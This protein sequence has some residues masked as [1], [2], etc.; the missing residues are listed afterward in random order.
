MKHLVFL[1]ACIVALVFMAPATSG[2]LDSWNNGTNSTINVGVVNI[3]PTNVVGAIAGKQASGNYVTALTGDV[4]ASGP[5]SVAA[6]L[7][8][9]GT[10]GTYRSVTTD[11]K[12][13]VTAGT[14]PTTFSGY[15]ISDTSANLAA[16]L[17]DETG[18]SGVAVFNSNPSITNGITLLAPSSHSLSYNGLAA[19]SLLFQNSA[20]P[21]YSLIIVTDNTG[22]AG[23]AEIRLGSA[24]SLLWKSSTAAQ[25]GSSDLFVTRDSAATLQMGVDAASPVAQRFKACD[26]SGTDK[27]SG[28]LI[29]DGGQSTGSGA[30]LRVAVKTVIPG[31]TGS[32]ANAYAT[33]LY[34]GGTLRVDTT[35][36]GN[37]GG[38]EDT[39]ITYTIPAGQLAVNGDRIKFDTWGS[40]AANA[41]TKDIKVY[42]G[43][44]VIYDTTALILN[45]V[46]WR[47]HGTVIRTGAA[48]QTATAEF[49]LSGTLLGALTTTTTTTSTPTETL[50]GT[51]VF[52][53]TGTDSGGVPVDNSIVQNAMSLEQ[54]WN[55]N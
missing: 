37:V 31:T 35:T 38:G 4:T 54:M 46:S 8:A 47:C 34:L 29:L 55:G 9:A 6:T 14:A 51:V 49:T 44:T 20:G 28:G 24:G 2:D 17:T 48:T 5:G 53:V 1:I 33:P 25:S 26:G 30:A 16:A 27:T 23:D 39:L 10:A 19:G 40:C 3:G 11:A 12:G 22:S 21:N 36:T 41:N 7:A 15:A 43:S 52:K 18:G 32:S 13:R 42:F 45:G 50:T